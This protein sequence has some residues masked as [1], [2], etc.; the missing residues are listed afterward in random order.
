MPSRSH[1]HRHNSQDVE[2]KDR[3]EVEFSSTA[4]KAA[5]SEPLV[6]F[7]VLA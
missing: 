5:E 6:Y 7:P 4:N 1:S 2:A 3:D